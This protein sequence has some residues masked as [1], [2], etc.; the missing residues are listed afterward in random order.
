MKN[1]IYGL[2]ASELDD[3]SFNKH[4]PI[5]VSEKRDLP[6][7]KGSG[8]K[9]EADS[10]IGKIAIK[11]I[12]MI[13]EKMTKIKTDEIAATKG[14][15]KKLKYYSEIEDMV[16]LLESYQKGKGQKSKYASIFFTLHDTLLK[17][18]RTFKKA[19][20][21]SDENLMALF[22]IALVLVLIEMATVLSSAL[23]TW[24]R[25]GDDIDETIGS[26]KEF[27]KLFDS[28]IELLEDDG[29]KK[30]FKIDFSKDLIGESDITGEF[31]VLFSEA[32]INDTLR[33]FSMGLAYLLY[34]IT[35]FFR[36]IVYLFFYG[37]FTIEKKIEKINN[38]LDLYKEKENEKRKRLM[39]EAVKEDRE[40]KVSTI[41]AIS[42]TEKQIKKDKLEIKDSEGFEL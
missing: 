8:N 27:K 10:I 33:L 6:F 18:K 36:Y 4:Y 30:F 24:A 22:Y 13:S 32:S 9:K 25:E 16:K 28:T 37:K 40:Y 35:A 3:T 29:M 41:E 21:N 31:L 12:S 42:D 17:R 15:F 7:G 20:K 14:D 19:F 2:F 11:L 1:K 39:D 34:K 38:L 5:L 26:K 23:L